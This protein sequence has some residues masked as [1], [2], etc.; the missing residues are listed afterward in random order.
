M[1]NSLA[2]RLWNHLAWIHF[3]RWAVLDP[4]C[5]EFDSCTENG[6]SGRMPCRLTYFQSA[7][8]PFLFVENVVCL[9]GLYWIW[10]EIDYGQRQN[11]ERDRINIHILMRSHGEKAVSS[12]LD[13]VVRSQGGFPTWSQGLL[14]SQIEVS[15]PLG[16][17]FLCACVCLCRV[18]WETVK[19]PAKLLV[20]KAEGKVLL[21]ELHNWIGEWERLNIVIIY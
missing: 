18:A 10:K 13:A 8:F 4:K 21:N 6:L 5:C 9:A 17:P 20:I 19:I 14:K 7:S 11:M 16:L 3:D 1:C 12:A 15:F 2:L